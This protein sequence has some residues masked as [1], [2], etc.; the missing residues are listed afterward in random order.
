[1]MDDKISL[2]IDGTPNVVSLIRDILNY[3]ILAITWLEN[4]TAMIPKVKKCGEC[5]ETLR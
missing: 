3:F 1:M 4:W 2:I 5:C